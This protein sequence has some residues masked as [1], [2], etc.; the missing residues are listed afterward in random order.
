[1]LLDGSPITQLQHHSSVVD[2]QPKTIAIIYKHL[3]IISLINSRILVDRKSEPF[4]K[5]FSQPLLQNIYG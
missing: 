2:H 1:M 4:G 3:A 5:Q